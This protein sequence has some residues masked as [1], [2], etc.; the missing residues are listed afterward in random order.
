MSLIPLDEVVHFDVV[1]HRVDTG[2]VSDADSPPTFDVFEEATDTPI[3]DDQAMT[4]RT[5]LTGNYRGTFTASAANGFEAGKWYSVVVSGTVNSVS[6][7]DVAMKFRVAPAESAAGVPKTDTTHFGGSAGTFASGRPEIVIQDDGITAAKIAANAI[8]ASEIADG[9]ID[10]GAIADGALTT[11]KLGSGF[12]DGVWSVTTRELTAFSASFKTGYALSSAGIQAIWDAATSSLTTV[13]SIGKL[14]VDNVNATISSRSSHAAADV[15]A[16][17][18]RLLTAGTNVVDTLEARLTATRAG[19]LDN[20]SAG[21]VAQ[22]SALATLAGKFTGITLLAEWLG[23]IAG[24]QT[25]NSTARTELRATGAG[26]GTY[27]ETVDSQEAIRDRG[28]AAWITATGF[29]TLDAAGVRSAVGLASANLDTQLADLPTN[30]E[31]TAAL[32]AADDAVLA[33]IA[34]LNNLS[35][36]Q[37]N[38]EVVDVLATDTYAEPAAVPAATASLKDKIAFLAALARNKVTQTATTQALRNDADSGNIG[39]AAV[40]DDGTTFT[41]AEW[42]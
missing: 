32:A 4:K 2:A 19:Y 29:S 23:L 3:L 8:G 37:V 21:A 28:D 31:L 38:A 10:A 9:A 27:D 36:A 15:W 20:L 22:A 34:A 16:V 33:A 26:S 39:T 7:K 1:T 5:S 42:Q 24:K 35:A 17:A 18:T 13:G 11:A 12:F 40:S 41:R 25:G 14:L 6:A 30:A